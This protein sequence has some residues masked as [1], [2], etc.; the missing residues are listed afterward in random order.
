MI[1]INKSIVFAVIL[2]SAI[3]ISCGGNSDHKDKAQLAD[4]TAL[5][6]KSLAPDIA[7]I[8][9]DKEGIIESSNSENDHDAN[10]ESDNAEEEIVK[11]ASS[12]KGS[13]NW[14]ALLKSY[15]DYI[16]HYV[17]LMKKAKNGDLNAIAQYAEY[18]QKATDLQ[19]KIENAKEDLTGLQVAKFLKLQ[20]KLMK[21]I[22]E[23]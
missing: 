11:T 7:E 10:E 2:I 21:V 19:E 1:N 6:S 22:G 17:V 20:T 15:E 4:E 5:T 23:M 8:S 14:D 3:H 9:D 16:D 13:E 18:M 12:S